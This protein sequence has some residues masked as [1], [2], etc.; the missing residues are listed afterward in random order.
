M[1][2]NR[3]KIKKPSQPI[4]DYSGVNHVHHTQNQEII[5]NLKQIKDQLSKQNDDI[6]LIKTQVAGNTEAIKKCN[7]KILRLEQKQQAQNRPS[8]NKNPNWKPNFVNRNT[9]QNGNQYRGNKQH[10]TWYNPSYQNAYGAA[11]NVSNGHIG[12]G[13]NTQNTSSNHAV[14]TSFDASSQN[15]QNVIPHNQSLTQGS[16]IQHNNG[17]N[18]N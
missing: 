5:S 9:Y 6:A 11:Q 17:Q 2:P 1:S 15:T 12:P 10:N 18:L 4:T 13:F 3:C 16:E 14:A 8:Y 7:V